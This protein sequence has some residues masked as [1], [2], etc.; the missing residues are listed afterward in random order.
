[1]NIMHPFY[2]GNGRATRIW[3]DL[4]LIKKLGKCVDW[5][6]IN[7]E[8]YLSAMKRSIINS[9][10]IKT[11]LKENLISNI[12]NRDVFMSNINQSYRY[13]NMSS[14]D[15]HNLD[16]KIELNEKKSKK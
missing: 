7:K 16:N 1:M 12:T 8:D 3:L 6:K 14:Y 9:L 13:E 4:L 5:Q 2:E 15:I 10:E 11:L